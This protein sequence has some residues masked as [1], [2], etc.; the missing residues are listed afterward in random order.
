MN[1]ANAIQDTESIQDPSP[2]WL[3]VFTPTAPV[4]VPGFPCHL[5]SGEGRSGKLF[6]HSAPDSLAPLFAERAGCGVILDGALYNRR[7]L[8]SE[9]GEFLAP[10]HNNDAEIVLA[11]YHRYGEVFLSR[12]RG[13]FA[14]VIWDSRNELLLCLRDPMGTYPMFYARCGDKILVSTSMGILTGHPQVGSAVNRAAIA[15]FFLDRFPTR[16]ETF[17]EGVERVPPGHVLRVARGFLSSYRY[18]DP[19]P[20]GEL[21]WLNAEE[22][23]QFDDLL[24]QAVSRCLSFGPTGILLS[25][26]LDSVSV[27]AVAAHRTVDQGLPKPLALSLVF[28]VAE[29]NEEIIQ[30]SV[31]SQLGMPQVLK[32]FYDATGKDGLLAGATAMNKLL[33]APIINTWWPAYHA[34]VREG[35]RRGCRTILTGTGGDEWLGVSPMLACDLIRDGDFRGLY[36]LWRG[37]WHSYKRPRLA[38]LRFLLWTAGIG[39]LVIP[40]VHKFVKKTAPG[41]LRLRRRMFAPLPKWFAPDTALRREIQERWERKSLRQINAES[42]PSFYIRQMKSG[43]DHPLVSWELEEQF[44]FNAMAGIRLLHPLWDT[45]VVDMLYR[46]PPL[47]L[48][49]GGRTKGLVRESLAR[50]FPDLGFDHQRK[51]EAT[52]FYRSLIYQEAPKVWQKLGGAST[53]DRLGIVDDR[54]VGP[55]FETFLKRRHYGDAHRA[56]QFLNLESWARAHVL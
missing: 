31:A 34:L 33:P 6:L 12:L 48:L 36:Q 41:A 26:G 42:A 47:M 46:T 56:W 39:P 19:A 53:L 32:T 21:K 43:L 9:L 44:S 20:N 17:F 7:E 37:N 16:E 27:A 5:V 2:R 10:S 49:Q 15:D 38:L 8:K 18:W 25:G 40:P 4:N 22:V 1:K 24:D 11:A 14:L 29:V 13:I 35:Q 50:R 23:R 28:P 52:H 30:R 55:S 51:V 45:D 3:G 54:K